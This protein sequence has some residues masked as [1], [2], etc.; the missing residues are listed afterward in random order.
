MSHAANARR[1]SVTRLPT[2]QAGAYYTPEPVVRTLLSWA[3]RGERDRFLD[4]SCGD[5]RFIACH[6][7][8]VGIEQDP[9]AASTARNRAPSSVIHEGD[10]F[11]W[12]ADARERFQAVGGNPP[13]IR[14]QTFRGETR[15]RALALC[16]QMGVSFSGLTSSWAPFIV[17]AAGLLEPGGNLAFV[18]PAEIGHAPYAA[19][20]MNYLANHFG[21]VHIVAYREK[22]FPDLSED[23]WLLSAQG[24]GARTDAFRMSLSERFSPIAELPKVFTSITVTE[25][26]D[27][28]NRRLRPYLLPT[29]ARDL[30]RSVTKNPETVR[31]SQL[32]RVGIG[33]V[34]GDNDFFHLRPS[35]AVRWELPQDILRPTVRRGEALPARRL[36]QSTVDRWWRN[37]DEILLLNLPKVG[38]LPPTVWRYLETRE[39]KLARAA[40]KCRTR[41]PWYSV[42]D[43]Q[44]PDFF[45]SYMAGRQAGLVR[46]DA[47]CTCTNSIH[48]V[49]FTARD[50]AQRLSAV[51][52]SKF[53]QLSCELEGHPLG[54]GMLKLEP[55]EAANIVIPTSATISG[56]PT[57]IV[58]GALS[59][60]RQWRHYG[61]SV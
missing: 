33:Y 47:N 5:G 9:H 3:I 53:V 57:A 52:D 43:V 22:L 49:N 37:D 13:F 6:P 26:R 56:L 15:N 16:E 20:V 18:V 12:A 29:D 2:K 36:T 46:N 21:V 42:P 40:Y 32:A 11:T 25:W 54:G 38:Q 4:P 58:D 14:Y 17:A 35:E 27:V 59:V 31:L 45:L 51:W 19:P 10:F 50:G 60:L 23:C 39:G 41:S 24:F 34:T 55:R 48:A 7:T 28:W 61:A 1:S 44:T 30:Y 8:S